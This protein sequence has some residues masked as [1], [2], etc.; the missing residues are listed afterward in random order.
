MTEN[1]K[2]YHYLG[3]AR[4]MIDGLEKV[5]GAAKYAADFSLGHMLHAKTVLSPYAHAKI[6]GIDTSEAKALPGVVAVLEAKDLR[7]YKKPIVSRNS[8]ILAKDKVLFAGQ[9]VV[10][11]VAESEA[12]A[13]DACLLIHVDYEPLP[14]VVHLE[15]AIKASSPLVWPEGLPAEDD[16]MSDMHA[17]VE[18]K[19][20]AKGPK[21]NN[22][23]K[24]NNFAWGDVEKGFA[25]ADVILEKVYTTSSV[26]QS[27]MEA[28]A[29]V[30]E[31]HPL[32]KGITLYTSTQG[33]YAV[34]SGVAKS[35]GLAEGD[36]IIKPMMI[37]GAFGAKYGI[38]EPLVAAIALKLGQNVRMVFSRSEDF[39]STT[40]APGIRIELKTGAKR[41]GS[42]TAL[43]AKVFVDNGVFSFNHGGIVSMLLGGYYKWPNL[44]ILAYE[45]HSHKSQAG[46]YR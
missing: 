19:A 21:Y 36:V 1:P 40:P 14:V 30:A 7:T 3:K 4:P 5:T 43:A 15:E 29:V 20:A 31:P 38:L 28:H 10:V 17:A 13:E 26:H 27:Y 16:D 46:A 9:P 23:S 42:L 44:D 37:G 32:G 41:D 18:D 12:I 11:V 45:V 25:E 24:E 35:L 39:L 8:A 2:A 34:R 22:V 33:Q 6:L